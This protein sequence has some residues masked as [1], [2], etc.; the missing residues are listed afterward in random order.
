MSKLGVAAV[1]TGDDGVIVWATGDLDLATCAQ[2]ERSLLAL[3]MDGRPNIVLDL[4]EVGFI[5][6]TG[7][8]VLVEGHRRAGLRDGCFLIRGASNQAL[9]LFRLTGLD[10]GLDIEPGLGAPRERLPR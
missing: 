3:Q 9:Q 2:L 8:R 10:Q 6:S 4:S 1:F 5:D 7:L